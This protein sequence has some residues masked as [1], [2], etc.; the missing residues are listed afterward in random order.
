MKQEMP[1]ALFNAYISLVKVLHLQGAIDM[2]DLI[3]E[4]GDSMDYRRRAKVETAE[5]HAL[6]EQIYDTLLQL[7]PSVVALKAARAGKTP[8]GA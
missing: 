7:E 3:K 4:I 8:G 5:D 1:M 6:L 2:G